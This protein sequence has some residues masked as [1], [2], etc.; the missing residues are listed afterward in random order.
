MA[1]AQRKE[2]L[3]GSEIADWSSSYVAEFLEING[4]A[5]YSKAFPEEMRFVYS[6][7]HVW[8]SLNNNDCISSPN[9]QWGS[10]LDHGCWSLLG[11]WA[12]NKS[13][14]SKLIFE[15]RFSFNRIFIFRH[16]LI[17]YRFIWKTKLI[18]VP[19][20]CKKKFWIGIRSRKRWLRPWLWFSNALHPF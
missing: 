13:I 3:I 9:L 5:A 11:Y 14:K 12:F 7:V 18:V 19:C 1:T 6:N 8:P 10:H 16:Y 17:N 20:R 15:K 4:C 2:T